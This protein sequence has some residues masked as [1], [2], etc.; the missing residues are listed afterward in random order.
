M[1]SVTNLLSRIDN[2]LASNDIDS[3]S[4][5]QRIICNTVTDAIK[6]QKAG[7]ATSV[8]EFVLSFTK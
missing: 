7:E 3:T 1:S 5:T 2:S 4:C 6:N 8:D